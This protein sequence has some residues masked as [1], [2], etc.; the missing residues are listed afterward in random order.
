MSAYLL[1]SGP[2][3]VHPYKIRETGLL[4]YSAEELSYYIY[5]NFY[6]IDEGFV[7]EELLSFIRDELGLSAAADHIFAMKDENAGAA[8]LLTSILRE[9]RY[10]S[11]VEIKE[12][13]LRYDAYRHNSLANR[14]V[15]K[16]DFLMEH[17]HFLAAIH[18]YHQFDVLRKDPSLPAEFYMKI[19][20]HMAVAYIKLGL[21]REA[22][23]AFMEA[24]KQYPGEELLRQ[25]Y[26][27]SLYSQIA[28]PT[29]LYS[30]IKP[31]QEAAWREEYDE[32]AAQGSLL[33]TTGPTVAMFAKDSIRRGEAIGK[34]IENVKRKYRT[35]IF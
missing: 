26:Q 23:D 28:I 35:A 20:Q 31:E 11:E 2:L 34:Y 4:I 32:V 12:F 24:Y 13:Q 30:D 5:N 27:F 33:A 15:M 17:G 18:I 8:V 3:A 10:Y 16:A 14:K 1:C 29:E 21:N 19:K 22:M 9:F 6:L 25:I 7:D